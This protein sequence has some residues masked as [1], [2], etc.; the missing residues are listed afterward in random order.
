MRRTESCGG[1]SEATKG[2]PFRLPKQNLVYM[3]AGFNGWS[4]SA[5]YR[6]T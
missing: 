1:E 3:N 4:D 5:T 2:I 6:C